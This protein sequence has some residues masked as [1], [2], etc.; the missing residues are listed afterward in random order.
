MKRVWTAVGIDEC[1]TGSPSYTEIL[2]SAVAS[3]GNGD[4]VSR[5]MGKKFTGKDAVK[6][7]RE[8]LDRLNERDYVFCRW[9]IR[10]LKSI[11]ENMRW[12]YVLA[13]LIYGEEITNPFKL[14]ID[15]GIKE[16]DTDFARKAVSLV[17]NLEKENIIIECGK[18]LD[19]KLPIVN[20]AHR[21]AYIFSGKG[22]IGIPPYKGKEFSVEGLRALLGS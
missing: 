2:Y 7:Q 16:R 6:R 10:D 3:N 11:N 21:A 20:M 22:K 9:N 4:E 15:G 18:G 1:Y 17:T 19:G 13:S 12:G 5:P 8:F 14:Y